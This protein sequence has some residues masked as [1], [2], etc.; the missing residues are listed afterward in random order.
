[1]RLDR[2]N[3]EKSLDLVIQRDDPWQVSSTQKFRYSGKLVFAI[4]P[5]LIG[6]ENQSLVSV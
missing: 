4:T 1:M 3:S 5:Q 2:V 6:G